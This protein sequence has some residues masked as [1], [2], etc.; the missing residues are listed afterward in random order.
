M[1]RRPAPS[2]RAGHRPACRCSRSHRRSRPY[3]SWRLS[4]F[5]HPRRRFLDR[6]TVAATA[7]NGKSAEAPPKRNGARR[8]QISNNPAVPASSGPVPNAPSARLREVDCQP[9][10]P[11]RPS[12]RCLR[13]SGA[14]TQPSKPNGMLTTPR[15][16]IGIM[17]A[18]TTG[19]ARRLPGRRKAPT[20]CP[21]RPVCKVA[22]A[23]P[24]A[25]AANASATGNAIETE[26]DRQPRHQ[27][28]GRYF[29]R[30]GPAR[31]CLTQPAGRVA[32]PS[33][34]RYA[35][36]TRRGVSGFCTGLGSPVTGM[37]SG[38]GGAA[39][40]KLPIATGPIVPR[41]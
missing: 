26:S 39:P 14:R 6:E 41:L 22:A 27:A 28:P 4:A 11:A 33:M 10:E 2:T 38:H 31:D 8:R 24:R 7:Q 23:G 20:G 16:P 3:S 36:G 29:R 13:P 25:F 1:P 35:S 15:I 19:M 37:L 12:S 5:A 32:D 18:E 17:T 9:T 34:N 40:P 30:G 21:I